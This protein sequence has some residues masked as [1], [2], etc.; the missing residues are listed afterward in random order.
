MQEEPKNRGAWSFMEPRLR[1]LLPDP[2][3]LTYFGRDEAASPA[4]GSYKMHQVEEQEIIS[5]ALEI[6]GKDQPAAAGNN[7]GGA[8][9]AGTGAAQTAAMPPRPRRRR[10]RCRIRGGAAIR[11]RRLPRSRLAAPLAGAFF[12]RTRMPRKRGG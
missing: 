1:E 5:H 7:G 3:V 2:A 9:T 4:T 11:A 10:H 12:S 6:A 8:A